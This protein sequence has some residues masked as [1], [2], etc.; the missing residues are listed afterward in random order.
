MSEEEGIKISYELNSQ[1]KI[2]HI[3]FSGIYDVDPS[4]DDFELLKKRVIKEDYLDKISM[5][6]KILIDN[7][8]E[9][10]CK[11]IEIKQKLMD[12][13]RYTKTDFLNDLKELCKYG[14]DIANEIIE[15]NYK[16]TEEA[17]VEIRE[18][19]K[20]IKFIEENEPKK[21]RGRQVKNNEELQ[22][23]DTHTKI[24]LKSSFLIKSIIPL[25]FLMI[26]KDDPKNKDKFS[27]ECYGICFN[28][29]K[30]EDIDILNKIHK[31]VNSRIRTTHYSDRPI[32]NL[33][34]T[35]SI[36]P[37]TVCTDFYKKIILDI[38]PKLDYDKSVISFLHATLKNL[39]SYLFR[40][41]FEIDYR[42]INLCDISDEN[43]ERLTNFERL[44]FHIKQQDESEGYCVDAKLKGLL[45]SILK[46][47]EFKITKKEIDYYKDKIQINPIQ[48]NLLFLYLAKYV[49][50]F[51]A[52]YN[53][54]YGD[55]VI[56][57]I[58]FKK[59]LKANNLNFLS[60]WITATFP[61]EFKKDKKVINT[62]DFTNNLINSKGYKFIMEKK[63]KYMSEQLSKNLILP[64][65]ISSIYVNK[66]EYTP[67][68]EEFK[69]SEEN[70]EEIKNPL[71]DIQIGTITDEILKFIEIG[72]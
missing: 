4:V 17:P 26:N 72:V 27:L 66:P 41:N 69:D 63:F 59:W 60:N 58:H 22:F 57:L 5:N 46:N 42:P 29:F 23:T 43:N 34:K 15:D 65:I 50:R 52:S 8:D 6:L 36:D 33:L 64:K 24:I 14:K 20:D 1:N 70:G 40:Y 62:K 3:K 7:S 71:E 53:M 32:W 47:K 2:L 67:S 37:N 48:N 38:I 18:E 35:M 11:Y 31:I 56:C 51:N 44:E 49:G 25:I 55:Y 30:E 9:F 10:A 54:K 68:Y 21:K 61:A 39:L 13:K 19:A 45:I 16:P 28:T 12:E